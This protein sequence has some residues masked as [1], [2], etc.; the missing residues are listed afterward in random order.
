M[1]V[2]NIQSDAA[3]IQWT[4]GTSWELDYRTPPS[5][6]IWL[7]ATGTIT[8]PYSL[9]GLA[10]NTNYE[11][12]VRN[13]CATDD[14]SSYVD[15]TF[16]TAATPCPAPT[17]VV[18]P[19]TNITQTGATVNWTPGGTETAWIVEYRQSG[20]SSWASLNTTA[21]TALLIDLTPDT[22]YCVRVF[23]DCGASQSSAT[24]EVCFRTLP[25]VTT[26]TINATSTGN[27]TI[28]P[29]GNIV[30]PAGVDTTFTIIPNEGESVL[31]LFI[32]GVDTPI[33]ANLK[34]TF[35]AVSSNHTISVDFTTGITNYISED[36]ILLY[37]NPTSGKIELRINNEQ[38]I[39]N[40]VKVYDVYGKLL[41]VLSS[42]SGESGVADRHSREGGNP[43]LLTIDLSNYPSG[44][45]FVRLNTDSGILTKKVVKK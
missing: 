30:V 19:S 1:T 40:N 16:T 14:M 11:V 17:S 42:H 7:P 45:Y 9:G 31:K 12:R 32:D 25:A 4:G 41:H 38:L 34:H 10:A 13:V 29:S 39:I 22:D 21:P 5:T 33:P 3:L 15:Q 27:G 24:E 44:I 8:N 20:N 35:P 28:S 43:L 23:A 2:N 37:P 26:Y 6:G 36:G 18:I